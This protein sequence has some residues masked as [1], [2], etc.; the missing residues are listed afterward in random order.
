[1]TGSVVFAAITPGRG[2]GH[3]GGGDYHLDAAGGSSR[4]EFLYLSRVRWADNALISNGISKS[5]RSWAAFTH[6]GE[7]GS[8]PHDDTYY[9]GS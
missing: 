3:S 5:S 4:C 7:V 9:R 8:A 6:Y 2:G 1:M